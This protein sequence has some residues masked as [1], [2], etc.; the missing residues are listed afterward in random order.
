MLVN[1]T[2][3]GTAE[4][5]TMRPLW[6]MRLYVLLGLVAGWCILKLP[7]RSDPADGTLELDIEVPRG[8][9]FFYVTPESKRHSSFEVWRPKN[10]FDQQ[11]RSSSPQECVDLQIILHTQAARLWHYVPTQLIVGLAQFKHYLIFSDSPDFVGQ[12]EIHDA[13]ADIDPRYLQDAAHLEPYRIQRS[14]RDQHI[15]VMPDE[16]AISGAAALSKFAMLP[17]LLKT[18]REE[19]NRS[20]YL[21]IG[22]DT[23]VFARNVCEYLSTLDPEDPLFLG[24][25]VAGLDHLFADLNSGIILSRAAMRAA[26]DDRRSDAWVDEYTK[27]VVHECC[28]D[29]MLAVFLQERAGISLDVAR[30]AGHFQGN[31]PYKV[32]SSARN[33][34]KT[35]VT[36]G[37][38]H[39]R[40]LQILAEYSRLK[41]GRILFSDI[42]LDFVKPYLPTSAQKNWDNAAKDIEFEPT[43][44]TAITGQA[45]FK[46]LEDC[47]KACEGLGNCLMLRYDP[48]LQYCGLGLSSTSLGK[49]VLHYD[50]GVD[51]KMCSSHGIRCQPR[52]SSESMTS[53]WF[54]ERIRQMRHTLAC[55]ALFNDPASEGIAWGSLDQAEGWWIRAKER[56][57]DF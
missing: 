43:S 30:S 18:W 15:H 4:G 14:I 34:C 32:P 54:V 3:V 23:Y 37:R 6:R 35:I 47:R 21:I 1:P 38:Q 33:W 22:D 41:K 36:T 52:G 19:P 42:Y 7:R 11:H 26:F 44:D 57:K 25:A 10:F 53:E 20:W 29:Y 48:Y 12:T 5:Q 55:D 2:A 16:V 56:H 24:S 45:P 9:S 46:T 50:V 39:P 17:S 49:P 8:Q 13:L 40:D 51:Q 27:R 31:P 28:G